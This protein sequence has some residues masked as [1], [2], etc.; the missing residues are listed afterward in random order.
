MI[1]RC[2]VKNPINIFRSIKLFDKCVNLEFKKKDF[3]ELE[4]EEFAEDIS[5]LRRKLHFDRFPPGEILNSTRGISPKQG[6]RITLELN[7][8]KHY[9]RSQVADV[10]E[11]SIVILFPKFGE[12]REYLKPGQPIKIYFWRFGDAG[13]TFSTKISNNIDEE[14]GILFIEHSSKIERTQRRLYFRIDI[15]LPLY[16][17]ALSPEQ[18]QEL[19]ESG[20]VKFPKDQM[21]QK[22]RITSIS[23][24]GIS[25]IADTYITNDKILWLY[26]D[27]LDYGSIVNIYGR[28]IRSKKIAEDKFK[29]YI[30]FV[31]ISRKDRETIVGF[32]AAKQRQRVTV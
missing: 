32:V 12:F 16:F 5:E 8:K 11:D 27:L 26:L 24:G 1:K 22:G 13:Y 23:G 28:V 25:F 2:K 29:I 31:L 10:R 17:T 14:P 19:R 21:P 6:I 7:G 3:S 30:E 9:Y 4:R 18:R 20:S 15:S